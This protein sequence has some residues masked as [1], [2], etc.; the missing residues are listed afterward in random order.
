MTENLT[1]MRGISDW[2]IF[3]FTAESI[4]LVLL[5]I[6]IHSISKTT[7]ISG[8]WNSLPPSSAP[9]GADRLGGTGNAVPHSPLVTVTIPVPTLSHSDYTSTPPQ[10][11]LLLLVTGF[12]QAA[13]IIL[14]TSAETRFSFVS[15][16]HPKKQMR[17]KQQSGVRHLGPLP[18]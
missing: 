10:P 6:V 17:V 4:L 16:D 2:M 5:L 9:D 18:S 8:G 12:L 14:S 11:L 7:L 1:D 13:L 3:T 15:S